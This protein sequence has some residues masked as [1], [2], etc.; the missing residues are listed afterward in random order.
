MEA[1][2]VQADTPQHKMRY[3]D[4][5]VRW[6]E[7]PTLFLLLCLP[8]DHLVE[9]FLGGRDALI[10]IETLYQQDIDCLQ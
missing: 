5:R 9:N 3:V 1:K 4:C 8:A 2:L 7:A 6:A 10:S